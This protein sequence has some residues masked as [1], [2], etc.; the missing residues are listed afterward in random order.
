MKVVF[1]VSSR[2]DFGLVRPVLKFFSNSVELE[3]ELLCLD[4]SSHLQDDYMLDG[5]D[6]AR[7]HRPL[8]SDLRLSHLES[9]LDTLKLFSALSAAVAK[10]IASTRSKLD[11][12]V[13]PGD[14]F[15]ILAATVAAYYS[16][17]PVVH[18]F[19]GD[20]SQ[21]GHLD[22][23]VRHAVSKL[24]HVHFPVCDDSATRLLRLGEESWR[25][26]NAGSPVVE[27]VREVMSTG[28]IDINQ[29]IKKK[30]YNLICTYHPITT[31]PEAAGAQFKCIVDAIQKVSEQEDISCI[32]THP[33]NEVGSEAI[34][35]ELDHIKDVP[36]FRIYTSLGWKDYLSVL[37]C[38]DLVIGNSSSAMLE[39]PIL[40]V[41][42]LDIGTRQKG[43]YCPRGVYREED[44][45]S[46]ILA[47]R[48][49]GILKLEARPCVDHPYGDGTTS[50]LIY[51]NLDRIS[52]QYSLKEILQK[53]I[54]Y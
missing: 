3:V 46:S 2:S 48:I 21:G 26:I 37:S 23:S 5:I 6:R 16:N 29:W 4:V 10:W 51:E 15:E 49:R 47:N 35:A 28:K 9:S 12:F 32:F 24:A 53:K 43:R 13:I 22:D 31:E 52:Q 1:V 39:A 17:I 44:Y 36:N 14:R 8:K 45:T 18:L 33:N 34:L 25:V 50:K 40:G 27:S 42:S 11:W 7:V 41:P 19:G 38:C 30:K 20:R 54:T